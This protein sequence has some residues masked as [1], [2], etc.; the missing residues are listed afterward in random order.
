[1]S[2]DLSV[3]FLGFGGHGLSLFGIEAG[4]DEAFGVEVGV[5]LGELEGKGIDDAGLVVVFAQDFGD[6]FKMLLG[7]DCS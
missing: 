7:H 1:V 5:E 4:F 2:F 3:N 6:D